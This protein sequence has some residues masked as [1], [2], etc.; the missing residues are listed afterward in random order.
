MDGDDMAVSSA[1]SAAPAGEL[2]DQEGEEVEGA[3]AGEVE[4][5]GAGPSSPSTNLGRAVQA[6]Q[7]W[8]IN[9]TPIAE[10]DQLMLLLNVP[11]HKVQPEPAIPRWCLA[12]CS[13]NTPM[14]SGAARCVQLGEPHET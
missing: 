6:V 3:G 13:S 1:A 7:S 2:H 9:C 14:W 11:G 5:E 8:Q 12:V 4:E 10:D